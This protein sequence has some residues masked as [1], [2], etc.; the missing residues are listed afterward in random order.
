MPVGATRSALRRAGA[1][2]LCRVGACHSVEREG[3]D[4]SVLPSEPLFPLSSGPR[5]PA[6]SSWWA[7]ACL[8]SRFSTPPSRGGALPTGRRRSRAR[9]EGLCWRAR[10]AGVHDGCTPHGP[11]G[12]RRTLEGA[13]PKPKRTARGGCQHGARTRR[14]RRARSHPSVESPRASAGRA[15]ACG[16]RLRTAV[17]SLRKQSRRHDRRRKG[18]RASTAGDASHGRAGARV[19]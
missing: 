17:G 15:A 2:R 14:L 3:G 7:I 8:R 9:H 6:R 13:S 12:T 11:S 1:A 16:P 18:H 4:A 19:R 10:S 5:A